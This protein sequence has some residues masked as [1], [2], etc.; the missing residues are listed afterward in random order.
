[1]ETR[2]KRE[3]RENTRNT[4]IPV[5]LHVNS[6]DNHAMGNCVSVKQEFLHLLTIRFAIVQKKK[7]NETQSLSVPHFHTTILW[8]KNSN[9]FKIR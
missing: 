1:M 2:R 3:W 8:T 7:K 4:R 5:R 6:I 9:V